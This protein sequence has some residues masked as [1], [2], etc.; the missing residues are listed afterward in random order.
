MVA[1]FACGVVVS[2]GSSGLIHFQEG[3]RQMTADSCHT[4]IEMPIFFYLTA[5]SSA[6]VPLV[7]GPMQ[8]RGSQ[9]DMLCS[10]G[11]NA[12]AKHLHRA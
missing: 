9:H 6:A 3:A 8:S 1:G 5:Y 2:S 11:T 7:I 4:A 12:N 10:H